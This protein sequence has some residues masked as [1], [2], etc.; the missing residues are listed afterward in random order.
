M[1]RTPRHSG[2]LRDALG[3]IGIKLTCGAALCGACTMQLNG[4]AIQSCMPPVSDAVC[5]KITTLQAVGSPRVG[6]AVHKSFN[7]VVAYLVQASVN[8]GVTGQ[9]NLG[10][11]A[12]PRISGVPCVAVHIVPSAVVPTGIHEP[13]LSQLTC[14]PLR[15]LPFKV[16]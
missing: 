4:A 1:S 5:Q 7:T 14:K 11:F 9:S 8:D 6:Q 15:D 3:M 13:G 10:E 2:V 12:V 16:A